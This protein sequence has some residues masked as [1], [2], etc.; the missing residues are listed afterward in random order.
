M[1][2]IGKSSIRSSQDK[3]RNIRIQASELRQKYRL[4]S[5][6]D[7]HPHI[8]DVGHVDDAGK[9]APGLVEDLDAG[10]L[11]RPRR[12]AVQGGQVEKVGVDVLHLVEDGGS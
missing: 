11:G 5:L 12:L 6:I 4:D 9:V 10:L 7:Q 1:G 2:E 3:Y 8:V